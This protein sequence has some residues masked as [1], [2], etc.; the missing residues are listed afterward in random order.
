MMKIRHLNIDKLKAM[1]PSKHIILTVCAVLIFCMIVGGSIAWLTSIG[2]DVIN[3]F[4]PAKVTIT[5][6]EDFENDVK[7]NV[8]IENTGNVHAYIRVA[9]VPAWVDENGNVAAQ[10]ASLEDCT[11]TWDEG[12]LLNTENLTIAWGEGVLNSEE[13]TW[14][15]GSDGYYYCTK[16][17]P[18]KSDEPNAPENYTPILI[19]ECKVKPLG[20]GIPLPHEY[21]FELRIVASAVQAIPKEAVLD[22]WGPTVDVDDDGKLIP[23]T[24]TP[25]PT[26]EPTPLPTWQ[27]QQPEQSP[28]ETQG[29]N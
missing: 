9:L 17:I 22:A 10:E 23:V 25:A 4:D 13:I 20:T 29:G 2:E 21:D 14:F 15:E 1:R 27:T 3:K 7:S 24:P 5:I 18:P 16:P 26:S 19:E 28:E 8:R 6:I 11:I 12:V